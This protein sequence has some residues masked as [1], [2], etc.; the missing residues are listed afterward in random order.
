MEISSVGDIADIAELTVE[1]YKKQ[2]AVLE[3]RLASYQKHGGA[4]V[5]HALNRKLNEIAEALN[6]VNI[7]NEL[8][9]DGKDKRFERIRALWQD[10]DKIAI[11]A[12]S[13]AAM[14]KLTGDEEKDMT[15]LIPFIET[16][17]ET[18]N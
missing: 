1:D 18:R 8:S 17:A 6:S 4:R 5:Y 10:V 13:L 14:Y 2:V 12:Q 16:V 11:A 7:T 15:K 3:Q 9:S